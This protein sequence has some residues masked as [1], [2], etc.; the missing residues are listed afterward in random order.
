MKDPLHTMNRTLPRVALG[1]IF[2][3][4]LA[5]TMLPS[6]TARAQGR[7]SCNNGC[8]ARPGQ[9]VQSGSSGCEA[10]FAPFCG[11]RVDTC[12]HTD[13]VSCSGE[14]TCVRVGVLDAGAPDVPATSDATV[15]LDRPTAPDGPPPPDAP[16]PSDAMM[17]IDRTAPPT[18]A[19]SRDDAPAAPDGMM[20][21]GPDGAT[22]SDATT[23]PADAATPLDGTTPPGGCVCPAGL[24]IEGVCITERCLYQPELGFVCA[25]AGTV[26][27]VFGNDGFCV[28]VCFATRCETGQFCDARSQGRCVADMCATIQC[29]QGTTCQRNQ[30]GRWDGP[31]GSLIPDDGAAVDGGV[32]GRTGVDDGGCGCRAGRGSL[33]APTAAWGLMGAMLFARRRRRERR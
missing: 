20:S 31:D 15:S 4:A 23:T 14:C 24:C 16:G 28:P 27:R 29:P 8:H 22:G 7:C 18:D 11:T 26:C 2:T 25:T 32:A 12:P 21:G 9:C 10:G 19:P 17:S 33:A 5:L 1:W 13:W 30:C 6:A 3:A